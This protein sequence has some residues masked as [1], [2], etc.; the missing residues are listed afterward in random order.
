[1]TETRKQTYHFEMQGLANLKL[2]TAAA[3]EPTEKPRRRREPF[4]LS[5]ELSREEKVEVVNRLIEC[6]R[7]L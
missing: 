1:M 4:I 3:S 6:V 5:T 2:V 7:E